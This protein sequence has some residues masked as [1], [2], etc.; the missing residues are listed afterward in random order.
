[1]KRLV[2]GQ[3][4]AVLLVSWLASA[5]TV[6]RIVAQVNDDII[7]L[8]E[9]NRDLAQT[10]EELKNQFTGEQLEQAM[11]KAE[12]EVLEQLI[13]GGGLQV[14]KAPRSGFV[15]SGCAHA[16]PDARGTSGA[17]VAPSA[18]NRAS[19]SVRRATRLTLP[20][21]ALETTKG[22]ARFRALARPRHAA[23]GP[24]G[25]S[26]LTVVATSAIGCTRRARRGRR[27]ADSD[28]PSSAASVRPSSWRSSPS[29]W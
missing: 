11:K 1:M 3:G 4:L 29:G 21:A 24:W 9:L 26:R 12:Q 17:P 15:G 25:T 28:T 2:L 8:S 13:H 18:G 10:R 5:K 20:N 19:V 27:P 22:R 23:L 16:R 14:P 6:D 7:T